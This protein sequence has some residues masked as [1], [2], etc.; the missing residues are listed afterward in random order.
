MKKI[1]ICLSIAISLS[2]CVTPS[3]DMLNNKFGNA[4]PVAQKYTGFWTGQIGPY[5]STIKLNPDGTGYSCESMGNNQTNHFVKIKV[6]N[7]YIYFSNGGRFKLLSISGEN[8]DV[9]N[10][11]MGMNTKYTFKKD[12]NL[13]NAAPYCEKEFKQQ[14][15]T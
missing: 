1:L 8:I 12:D 10:I 2:G 4:T 6:D 9:Q 13:S 15:Q 3:G 5:T 7:Q 14:N 11:Y